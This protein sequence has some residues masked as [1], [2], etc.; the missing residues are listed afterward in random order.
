MKILFYLEPHPIRER[1]E[2]FSWI[3]KE[4]AKMLQD[5]Y[6][7]TQFNKKK[8]LVDMRILVSRYYSPLLKQFPKIK[9]S[10]IGLTQEENNSLSYFYDDWNE[11]S[12][13]VWKDLMRGEGEVS[14]FYTKILS[15]IKNETFDFDVII[16]WSTNGA[17]KLFAQDENIKSISME[18]GCT[19]TPFFES[20]YMDFSGVNGNAITRQ[21][22]IDLV[23]AYKIED[24]VSKI[25][26]SL[27]G[28]KESDGRFNIIN[29]VYS[30][31][32]YKDISKNILI[33][34]QL[35]DDSNVLMF[36]KYE[37]MLEFLKEILPKLTEA[38]YRCFIKPHPG[39]KGRKFTQ[40]GHDKCEEYCLDFKKNVY[41]IDDIDNSVD[42]L[43]LINK[44]YAI[45]TVNSSVGFEA[46]LLN[47]I[48]VTMGDGA[49][50]MDSLPSF[51]D[52]INNKIDMNEYQVLIGKIANI[53]INNYLLP[54]EYVFEQNYF[55]EYLLQRLRLHD[56]Y[57]KLDNKEFTKYF[58][59]EKNNM[60]NYF[61]LSDSDQSF[62]NQYKPKTVV[63]PKTIVKPKTENKIRLQKK[64]ERGRK[65]QKLLHSPGAYFKDAFL[66]MLK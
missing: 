44:M 7:H 56:A 23:P 53:M 41:W 49:Y 17:V 25:P 52:L 2:S 37:N 66:N 26:Y 65:M 11:K 36:S 59:S 46:L 35:D 32:I 38:G 61:L 55:V 8:N 39:A 57:L 27:S 63:K 58:I 34:M 13:S 29:S 5:K 18:L 24:I 6:V 40:I 22:E 30:E 47:K 15:R 19:R 33:P 43:A 10:F 54:K 60:Q 1:Y 50:S 45:V 14:N 48:V 28:G 51:D 3:G 12:I 4:V 9:P 21:L 62:L 16:Y 20:I 64:H 42:Y 31:D